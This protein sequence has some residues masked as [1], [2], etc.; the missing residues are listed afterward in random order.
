MEAGYK[1]EAHYFPHFALLTFYNENQYI[2]KIV[3]NFT[4]SFLE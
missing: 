4:E 3:E 1:H 2:D